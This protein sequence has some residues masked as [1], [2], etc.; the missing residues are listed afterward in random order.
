MAATGLRARRAA[1]VRRGV[2][3]LH[4]QHA[5]SHRKLAALVNQL[6]FA[7]I[8]VSVGF[9]WVR[10][11]LMH[12]AHMALHRQRELKHRVPARIA[13]NRLWGFDDT[14]VTYRNG[15]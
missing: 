7:Q 2:L 14:C 12:E 9:T 5:L 11:L 1:W 6:Y 10:E 15:V 8:G 3:E 4:E 13:N